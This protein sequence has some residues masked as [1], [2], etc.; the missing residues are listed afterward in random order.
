MRDKDGKVIHLR[1]A[2]QRDHDGRLE[3]IYDLADT[4]HEESAR[5]IYDMVVVISVSSGEARVRWAGNVDF[6]QLIGQL[7]IIKDA[8]LES[9][10]RG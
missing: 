5:G 10:R 9:N 2:D 1:T 4:L 6:A 7:E 3:D 8:L